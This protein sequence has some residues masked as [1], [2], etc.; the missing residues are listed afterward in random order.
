MTIRILAGEHLNALAPVS[1]PDPENI[2]IEGISLRNFCSNP[3]DQGFRETEGIFSNE[4]CPITRS[5]LSEEQIQDKGLK[6]LFETLV[7]K[8]EL[9]EH[10][11]CLT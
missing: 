11:S 8:T 6:Q 1:V 3:L 5:T 9:D 4:D 10:P 7:D 2:S